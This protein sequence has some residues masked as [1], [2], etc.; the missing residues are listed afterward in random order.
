MVNNIRAQLGPSDSIALID[1]GS[2]KNGIGI[3]LKVIEAKTGEVAA[4][5]PYSQSKIVEAP[6]GRGVA[7][8]RNKEGQALAL[9]INQ[10]PIMHK[11]LGW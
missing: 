2:C 4:L 11:Q 6:I 1:S 5:Q 9:Y 8:V 7:K 10:A 3:D